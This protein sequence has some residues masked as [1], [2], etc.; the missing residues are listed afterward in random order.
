MTMQ[1]S[2]DAT[3]KQDFGLLIDALEAPR[4]P[5]NH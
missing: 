3:P 5:F 2:Y 4:I 1:Q